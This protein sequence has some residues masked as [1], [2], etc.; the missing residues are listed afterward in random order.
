MA[1]EMDARTNTEMIRDQSTWPLDRPAATLEELMQDPKG[2][3]G[4]KKFMRVADVH[5]E[6]DQRL[7]ENGIELPKD[8][9]ERI[10][11]ALSV[12]RGKAVA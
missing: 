8:S 10:P 4:A 3:P 2:A 5:G 11:L 9:A 1:R 7:A 12:L 6:L